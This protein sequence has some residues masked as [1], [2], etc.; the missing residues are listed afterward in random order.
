M[1][2]RRCGRVTEPRVEA[3][4][5]GKDRPDNTSPLKRRH[6]AAPV[7][8]LD[9]NLAHHPSM[10]RNPRPRAMSDPNVTIVH[11]RPAKP[12]TNRARDA[13][14]AR[15]PMTSPSAY[16]PHLSPLTHLH[17]PPHTNTNTNNSPLTSRHSRDRVYSPR[18]SRAWI[19][20]ACPP[21]PA[22]LVRRA[23]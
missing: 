10:M 5:C 2:A 21:A 9:Y 3:S 19:V 6:E 15:P 8:N 13:P 23:A 16:P 12:L 11:V 22:V 14:L 4:E 18:T 20:T 17:T 1:R 7:A